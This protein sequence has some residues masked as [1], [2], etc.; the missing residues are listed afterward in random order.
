MKHVALFVPSKQA[1]PDGARLP[2]ALDALCRAMRVEEDEGLIVAREQRLVGEHA[3]SA[4][5]VSER[6]RHSRKQSEASR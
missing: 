6:S 5:K 3:E 4:A 1:S 2:R